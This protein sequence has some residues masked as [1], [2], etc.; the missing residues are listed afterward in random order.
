VLDRKPVDGTGV[1]S[2]ARR[3]AT[4]AGGLLVS[5]LLLL[6]IVVLSVAVGAKQ[7]PLHTVWDAIF[8][9]DGSND[10][11]IVRELRVPRTILGV[12]VG[13]AMALAGALMQA[14]S[15]NPLADPGL[16]GVNTGSALAVVVAI[17]YLGVTSLTGYVWFAM[18][19][20]ALTTVI[21]YILGSAGRAGASPVRLALAGTAV[22]AACSG[23]ISAI[24]LL[25]LAAF[26]GFRS[27]SVGSLAGRDIGVVW[28]VLPFMLVGFV[29]ALGMAGPL[30]ALALGDD[31]ARALGAR[32]ARI[33]LAGVIAVTLLCGA[34]TAAVGPIG[35]VGLVI[36]H[37]V[38]SVTGPNQRWLLPYSMLLGPILLLGSD[39]I[40]RVVLRP[41][42]LQVGI[43]TAA[44]GAPVF[45]MLV[46][47]R[48]LTQ[49]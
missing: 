39:V 16:L 27:W 34:G 46:R 29:V 1:S 43:V 33:R 32:V 45:I 36:P 6:A 40:G 14:L 7:I 19:G 15:R 25:D 26:Q 11:V 23:L 30:N 18:L 22:G 38:R 21:V 20:A 42:E 12:L 9:N 5:V 28:Q 48:R 31:T 2:V 35:F 4:L 10:A 13:S 3:R 24:V 49:L 17:S 47:R 41:G 37:M 8:H 44:V